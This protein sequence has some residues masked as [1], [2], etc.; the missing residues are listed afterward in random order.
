M[1][2]ANIIQSR[3][4]QNKCMINVLIC[5]VS[6]CDGISVFVDDTPL[7]CRDLNIFIIKVFNYLP[8]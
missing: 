3:V 6:V 5:R 4:V 8:L 2:N 7:N 1:Y